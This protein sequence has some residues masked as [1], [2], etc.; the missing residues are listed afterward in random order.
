M[1]TFDEPSGCCRKAIYFPV[2]MASFVMALELE[3]PSTHTGN[4]PE[5]VTIESYKTL[6][7]M[8][9]EFFCLQNQKL[10]K[11]LPAPNTPQGI[12]W[13]CLRACMWVYVCMLWAG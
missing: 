7:F 3:N 13:W 6:P 2:H 11:D 12:M 8:S 5:G 1:T 10:I 4:D 9:Y